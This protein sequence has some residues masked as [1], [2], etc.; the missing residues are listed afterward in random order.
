MKEEV[1]EYFLDL[2]KY[3]ENLLDKVDKSSANNLEKVDYLADELKKFEDRET[4][5][6][7][8]L[9]YV[10]RTEE[11][12]SKEQTTHSQDNNKSIEI[13]GNSLDKDE[14]ISW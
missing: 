12:L 2:D 10:K 14:G 13:L 7:D 3:C 5:I 4:A 9:E 6:K 11:S 8:H 1:E